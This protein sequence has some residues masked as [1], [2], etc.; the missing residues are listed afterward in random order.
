ME[1]GTG[2]EVCYVLVTHF[3][4]HSSLKILYIYLILYLRSYFSL[5]TFF[6]PFPCL[7][8]LLPSLPFPSFPLPLPSL[9]P[10]N[11]D[12]SKGKKWVTAHENL[13]LFSSVSPLPSHPPSHPL[14]SFE[15]LHSML[16]IFDTIDT[17]LKKNNLCTSPRGRSGS[18]RVKKVALLAGGKTPSILYSFPS[19]LV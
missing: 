9:A 11:L 6:S 2:V 16:S 4:H 3:F 13:L 7:H 18:L 17:C 14:A 12:G 8:P 1:S 10:C 15:L 5:L 19:L